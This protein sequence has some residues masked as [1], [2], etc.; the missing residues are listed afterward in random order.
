MID[1]VFHNKTAFD[2]RDMRAWCKE[3]LG[4]EYVY[5]NSRSLCDGLKPSSMM[6][7]R[8]ILHFSFKEE[9]DATF[10]SLRWE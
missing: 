3:Q 4:P 2:Y 1:I 9:K 8:G 7:F 10:F 6:L 5:W